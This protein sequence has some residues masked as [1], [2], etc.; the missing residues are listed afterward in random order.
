MPR[1]PL[2]GPLTPGPAIDTSTVPLDRVRTAADLAR[3]LDQVRRLAGAP[4]NRAIAAASG[5][6]FGRTKVGQVLAGELP[7]RGFL[8]AYLAVCGV[9]EDE[10]GEWL[11][12]WARLIAV[13]SR[14]DAV[15]SLRAEVRRLTADLARAIET[16]ARDLRA[17]RD[18]RDRAL[19]E[20][21]RL[22]ARADDQ[23]WGQVGSMRGT[24]D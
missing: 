16:G 4:S 5:G 23:A 15:E 10:L 21:A 17:A 19:Q 3:C 22:R 24:L 6:R 20:C 2:T 1:A 7:Q 9:P 11:D 12:A 18:E 8:V 13:D 14:A